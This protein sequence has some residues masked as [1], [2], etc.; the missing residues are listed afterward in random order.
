MPTM[1]MAISLAIDVWRI[2]QYNLAEHEVSPCNT[3]K[4]LNAEQLWYR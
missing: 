3:T 4:Y 2:W 1:N